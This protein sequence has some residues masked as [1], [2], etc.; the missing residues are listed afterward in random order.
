VPSDHLPPERH[1]RQAEGVREKGETARATGEE[2]AA[3]A[4]AA[5]HT[6]MDAVNAA[7]ETLQATLGDMTVVEEIRRTLRDLWDANGPDSDGARTIHDFM[8]SP[9]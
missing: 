8:N 1:R 9:G 5:C 6:A 4:D 7:A 2:A 3:A